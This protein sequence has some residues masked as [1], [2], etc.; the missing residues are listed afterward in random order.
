MCYVYMNRLQVAVALQVLPYQ[1][2]YP[3]DYYANQ[4]LG[5]WTVNNEHH[6]P[7][8]AQRKHIAVETERVAARTDI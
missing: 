5:A 8:R 2:S 3:M 1:D 4:S 6:R 7:A